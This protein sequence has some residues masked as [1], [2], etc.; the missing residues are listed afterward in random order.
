MTWPEWL[1]QQAALREHAGLRRELRPRP[2]DD[3]FVDLAGNDYLG[4]SQHPV[5]RAAAAEAA[6]TWGAGA[7]GARQGTR[8]LERHPQLETELAA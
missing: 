1:A 4:L 2:A 7:G 6:V 8:A 5:V 3:G